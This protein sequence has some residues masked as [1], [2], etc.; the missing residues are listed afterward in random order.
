VLLLVVLAV[1]FFG[2]AVFTG[3][4]LLPLDVLL[5]MV[6]WKF[7]AH[8]F[9]WF[10]IAQNPMIDPIQQYYPWRHFAVESLRQ[11]TIPLW[12]PYAFCGTPFVANLQSAVF[13]PPN[14]L[15][16]LMPVGLGF[17]ATVVLHCALAGIFMFG[18]LRTLGLARGASLVG[19]VAFMFNGAL[20]AW[21]EYPA[22]GLWVMVWLP[23]ILLLLERA[24]AR[25]S[26][27]AAAGAG[28]AV[29]AQF[30]GGH[31]QYSAYVLL[32]FAIFV[33]WRVICSRQRCFRVI[34]Y[35]ALALALG[36]GIAA[37]QLLPAV[38][39]AMR[40][41]RPSLSYADALRSAFPAN[42]LVTYLVPNFFGN[43]SAHNYWGYIAAG[44][45][46][47]G[48][49]METCGYVGILTLVLAFS[50]VSLKVRGRG[51]FAA[52]AGFALLAALGT[53]V[54]AVLYYGVPG[55]NKLAGVARIAYLAAFGLAG[56]AAVG[57][58]GL[59][60]VGQG[61]LS[62]DFVGA[63]VAARGAQPLAPCRTHSAS[64][65]SPTRHSRHGDRAGLPYTWLAFVGAAG[66]LVAY[67]LVRFSGEAAVL[68]NY[69]TAQVAKFGVFAAA[70]LAL[71][72]LRQFGALRPAA[73]AVGA[74]GL[75]AC[76]LFLFG[77]RFNPAN[78]RSV[79]YFSTPETQALQRT[80]NGGRMLAVGENPLRDWMPPN[81]PMVYGLSDIQ[82]SDSLFWGRYL[83]FL[84]AVEPAA[85]GPQWRRLDNPALDL[86]GVRCVITSGRLGSAREVP[87]LRPV[88]R[89]GAIVYQRARALPRA[90]IPRSVRAASDE[91]ILGMVRKGALRPSEEALVAAGSVTQVMR[92]GDGILRVAQNDKMAHAADARA[93][94]PSTALRT[95]RTGK[96]LPYTRPLAA[97]GRG[98]ARIAREV[99]NEVV[100]DAQCDRE[101][102]LRLADCAYP[103]WEVTV[104]GVSEEIV[105]CDYVFRAVRLPAGSHRVIFRYR[106]TSF[107]LGLFLTLLAVATVSA[108][109]GTS[110]AGRRG[111]RGN[112]RSTGASCH[113]ERSEAE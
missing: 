83:R 110:L 12:N 44:R 24:I 74:I 73:F 54:Y 107:R 4:V 63:G 13:Y 69:E 61:P 106:P 18:L 34:G 67:A 26:I 1:A 41:Q 48:M 56:L 85:P 78:P 59:M 89:G 7:Q 113:S 99:P 16:L 87:G 105:P 68:G 20:V 103:G 88:F 93:P 32:G 91:E 46:E 50:G 104:D 53:P 5:V 42:Q 38:E 102:L 109:L 31:Y 6:P 30:L 62:P 47:P 70:A 40:S 49:F 81:T 57:A 112:A 90:T 80:C 108:V 19:A 71:V 39:L 11:G 3:K 52:V 65:K 111:G 84:Q 76:D 9:P 14:L 98:T 17:T 79:E 75:I 36:V 101:C 43:P 27:V 94:L 82:G 60:D 97:A 86:M 8:Q 15:F 33:V 29:G 22:L 25:R 95:S 72:A 100:I 51:L 2:R 66:V 37:V 77:F 96:P 28:C 23:L 55:F 92:I 10:R 64:R 45:N 58:Q 21:A 35:A